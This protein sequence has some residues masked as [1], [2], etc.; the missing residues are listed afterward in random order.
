[1]ENPKGR[2]SQ[3]GS[4]LPPIMGASQAF[5]GRPNEKSRGSKKHKKGKK[6]REESEENKLDDMNDEIGNGIK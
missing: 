2:K 3:L 1:M 4:S 5:P 6:S